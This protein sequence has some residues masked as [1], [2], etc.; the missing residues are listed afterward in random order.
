[1]VFATKRRFIVSFIALSLPLWGLGGSA[2]AQK[3]R[4]AEVRK[5][6]AEAKERMAQNDQEDYP[7]KTCLETTYY[8][9]APGAGPIKHYLKYYVSS[10]DVDHE[11]GL[12]FTPYFVS[13]SYNAGA[14]KNY[15]EFLLDEK[16]GK[17]LFSYAYEENGDG[18]KNEGRYY[19]NADASLA[20]KEVTIKAEWGAF[21]NEKNLK[22]KAERLTQAFHLAMPSA[23]PDVEKYWEQFQTIYEE[24]DLDDVHYPLTKYAFIDIDEDGIQEVWVRT[25]NDED[26]AI[27]CF[28][29]EIG[30]VLIIA[31]SEGKRPSI[32]KGWVGVGYPAGGPSYFNH[33]VIVQDSQ[34]VYDFTDFQVEDKHEYYLGGNE[35]SA[36]EAKKIKQQ[37]KGEG[38][39][40]SPAWRQR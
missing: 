30:P 23:G 29:D 37:I 18:T 14:R 34:V 17:L 35:I 31:E 26:G 40:L 8:Y 9:M 38:R 22:E 27:F 16:T 19:Y 13:D 11:G 4:V 25:E 5:L 7:A 32:A 15:E 36:S 20:H 24:E 1:M 12:A 2:F 39:A 21:F 28:D 33:Y 10:R 3:A 6:Y